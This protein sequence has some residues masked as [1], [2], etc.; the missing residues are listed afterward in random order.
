MKERSHLTNQ[1]IA[2]LSRVPLGTV[3]RIMAGQTDNPSYLNLRDIVLAMGGTMDELGEPHTLTSEKNK[4]NGDTEPMDASY[5]DKLI[6]VYQQSL[7]HKDNVIK[8]KNSWIRTLF[9]C[10][11]ILVGI[12]VG[13]ALFDI[14]NPGVGYVRY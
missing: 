6:S 3:N 10:L 7:T 11:I 2:E 9:I 12:F 8:E 5:I 4:T 14:F 13:I 1:Q